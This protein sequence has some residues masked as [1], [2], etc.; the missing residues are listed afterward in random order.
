MNIDRIVFIPVL[1]QVI[2]LR[3]LFVAKNVRKRGSPGLLG[4]RHSHPKARTTLDPRSEHGEW[5][6]GSAPALG[7]GGRGFK[8]PLPDS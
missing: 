8:S 1:R 5:R 3:S 4:C 2:W 7:A 6:S